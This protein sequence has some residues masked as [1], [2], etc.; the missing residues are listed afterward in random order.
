VDYSDRAE[1]V[2][3]GNYLEGEFMRRKG[4]LTIAVFLLTA[5]SIV[6]AQTAKPV[7]KPADNAAKTEITIDKVESTSIL[8]LQRILVP[9]ASAMP[10][11]K[12]GFAPT[13]GEFKGVRTFAEQLKHVAAANYRFA[14]AILDEKPPADVG[15]DESGPASLKSKDEILKYLND[16]FSYV[17]KAVATMDAKNVVSPIKSPFG[18]DTTRLAMATLIVG[19]CYDHY[20]QMVEYLRMNG[21]VPPASQR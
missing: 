2:A 10:E 12:Y 5:S 17:Q 18:G 21:I 11:E 8:H 7:E 20:G 19:H 6:I 13:N 3:A 4:H 14:S 1:S 15:E 16:S 9:L